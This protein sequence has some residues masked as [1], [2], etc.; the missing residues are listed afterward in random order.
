MLF[1]AAHNPDGKAAALFDTQDLK[2]RELVS[3]AFA[4]VE[5]RRNITA[6]YPHCVAR[7]ESMV[8]G[9][10]VVAQP[11]PV[12]VGISLPEKDQPIYL[13]ALAC[14]ATHLLTGG[15]DLRSVQEV[16]GHASLTTTQR[17]THVSA[18]RLRATYQLAHPR[19]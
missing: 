4:I 16:L 13:A 2:R 9:L 11:A 14:R 15:S 10:T 19:A 5:A 7:L 18:E 6:R 17:Y 12:A 8:A 1:T 3:S